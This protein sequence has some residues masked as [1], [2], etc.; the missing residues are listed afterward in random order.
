[1]QKQSQ[2]KPAL[3][4]P[5]LGSMVVIPAGGFM[6]GGQDGDADE[7]PAH[8][9]HLDA[10]SMDVYEVTGG[11]DADFLRSGGGHPPPAWDKMK[12]MAYQKRPVM[13]VDWADALAFCKSVGKRL[14]T[15]AE[16]EKAARGTD[17][18][19]YPWGNDPPTP[20]HASFGKNGSNDFGALAQVGTME[21]G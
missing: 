9:G 1:E 20:L 4:K 6:M 15:E 7:R 18:R 13:G 8:K 14:P 5:P 16:W 11:E 2:E 3:P 10:F 17:G 21:A 19:L 12:Q